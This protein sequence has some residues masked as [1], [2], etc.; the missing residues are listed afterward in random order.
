MRCPDCNEP[1][2][3]SVGFCGKCGTKLKAMR[4]T[5]MNPAKAKVNDELK[6]LLPQVG[7]AEFKEIEPGRHFGQHGS[8]HV[9]V[10]VL[11]FGDQIAVRSV[12]PVAIGSRLG[13]D[14][15]RFLLQKNAEFVF[16]GFGLTAQGVVIFS[17]TILASSMDLQELGASVKT[18]LLMADHFD[19]EIVKRW[20]GKTMA[21]AVV[22][23][24]L[25]TRVAELLR[26]A[27]H[28]S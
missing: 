4:G 5:G 28:G 18:I 21:D 11:E 2:P 27:R 24:M 9:D 22:E 3:D 16:G 19:N 12:A 23:K 13:P 7:V 15:L 17:H 25:P 1:W 20:G 26:R 6:R 14:L 10:T 8:T